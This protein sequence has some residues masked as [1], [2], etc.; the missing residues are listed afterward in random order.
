MN[1]LPTIHFQVQ[2]VSFR[3]GS[4]SFLEKG[5]TV[6]PSF[7]QLRGDIV[8]RVVAISPSIMEKITCFLRF[9]VTSGWKYPE[10]TYKTGWWFQPIWKI[11]VKM[12]I[13]P[14]EG[15][16]KK[17]LK[18]P[19]S[20]IQNKLIQIE[21]SK[22]MG[23]LHMTCR[24]HWWSNSMSFSQ[25]LTETKHYNSKRCYAMIGVRLK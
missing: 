20:Y 12:G 4:S 23:F 8:W 3:K 6:L 13:F 21:S 7:C 9:F 10:P 25:P 22:H 5:F 24:V 15:W 18:P 19:P 2:F 14:K 1:H 17:C 11:L 16:K